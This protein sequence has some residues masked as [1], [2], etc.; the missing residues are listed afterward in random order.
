[1]QKLDEYDYKLCDPTRQLAV[2]ARAVRARST[3]RSDTDALSS[4]QV[5]ETRLQTYSICVGM[6]VDHCRTIYI[7]QCGKRI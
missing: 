1:M 6:Y 2:L 7:L 4:G 3:C 5:S